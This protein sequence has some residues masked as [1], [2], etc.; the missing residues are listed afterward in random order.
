MTRCYK[1]NHYQKMS[2]IFNISVHTIFPPDWGFSTI[3]SESCILATKSLLQPHSHPS[4][5][6]YFD[7]FSFYNLSPSLDH[8]LSSTWW[9]IVGKSLETRVTLCCPWK[10]EWSKQGNPEAPGTT[11]EKQLPPR[12]T[13]MFA[14]FWPH[15]TA[16]K[17]KPFI[18]DFPFVPLISVAVLPSW[19]SYGPFSF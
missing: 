17:T 10:M 16:R 6:I 11:H 2:F 8:R 7:A 18:K 19:N 4:I 13:K 1:N 9:Q 3:S 15:W 14:N 12:H 5:N